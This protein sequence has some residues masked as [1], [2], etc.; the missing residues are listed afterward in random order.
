MPPKAKVHNP[1]PPASPTSNRI[2][3][4]GPLETMAPLCTERAETLPDRELEGGSQPTHTYKYF[5]PRG[6]EDTLLAEPVV[7]SKKTNDPTYLKFVRC[8][9][10]AHSCVKFNRELNKMRLYGTSLNQYKIALRGKKNV[11]AKLLWIDDTLTPE[12]IIANTKYVI[13]PFGYKYL[14]WNLIMSLLIIYAMTYM[15]YGLVFVNNSPT[16]EAIEDYMNIFFV[17]DIF[18]N[19]FTVIFDEEGQPIV[20]KRLIALDY[21]KGFFLLDLLSS[22][23]FNLFSSGSSAN[24][25]LRILKIPRLI[26][27]FKLAKVLRLKDLYKGTSLS[28]FLK[29]H[30]GVLKVIS[31]ALYT[32]IVLHFAACI[33]SAIAIFDEVEFSDTWMTR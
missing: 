27:M 4:S 26:R 21:I 32:I 28:Y 23:P 7:N 20:S 8:M 5:K 22:I 13:N 11:K 19:F 30:G 10:A 12:Q 1:F 18:V 15:P 2:L 16:K 24:K 9:L 29:I 6:Q 17:I 33:F 31:L 25:L 14:I 3:D